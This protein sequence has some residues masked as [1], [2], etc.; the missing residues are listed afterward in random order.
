MRYLLTV[1]LSLATV[2]PILAQSNSFGSLQFGL[3]AS[4]GLYNTEFNESY[5]PTNYAR[6][7][8]DNAVA[9]SFPLE[10]HLGLVPFMSLGLYLQPGSY[11]DTSATR[12][13]SMF[14]GGLSPRFY[15]VNGDRFNWFAGLEA[16]LANL[17]IKERPFAGGTYQYTFGGGHFRIASGF[18]LYFGKVVGMQ[19]QMKYAVYNMPLWDL[20]PNF[21]DYTARLKVDG[22]EAQLGLVF[23]LGGD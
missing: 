16:G 5:P 9:V 6:T 18:N 1:L 12:S 23:K 20:E 3:G 15:I 13:N 21:S 10:V 7:N 19:M 17:V 14:I 2:L 11:L 4:F 22:L 8:R